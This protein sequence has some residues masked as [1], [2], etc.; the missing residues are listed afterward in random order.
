MR[1]RDL[2][3]PGRLAIGLGFIVASVGVATFWALAKTYGTDAAVAQ[4]SSGVDRAALLRN[5][6]EVRIAILVGSLFTLI[7]T[8][9]TG[10]IVARSVARAAAKARFIV[11]ALTNGKFDAEIERDDGD[12]IGGLLEALGRM[13][14]HLQQRFLADTESMRAMTFS[15][16]ALDAAST[17][18]MMI[19]GQ[20]TIRALNPALLA[21]FKKAAADIGAV[22]PGFNPQTLEGK[23]L[24]VFGPFGRGVLAGLASVKSSRR[25]TLVLGARTFVITATPILAGAERLG[26]VLEWDDQTVELA[27]EKEIADLVRRAGQGDFSTRVN[28][29][30][31]EGFFAQLGEGVNRLMETSSQGLDEVL[32]ILGSLASGDLTQ[33][34]TRDYEGTFGDIKKDAN[35]TVVQLRKTVE[36]IRGASE[37]INCA[38]A[39]MAQGNGDLS[40]RTESQGASL[41]ETASSMEQLTATVRQNAENARQANQLAIGASDVAVK[42]GEVVAQVV[43]TMESITDSSKKIAEIIGV[44]DGIAFQTNILALNA[45][46]EAARAGEQGRGFAVVATEVRNLAQ[47]SAEAAKEIKGLIGDSS[48]KVDTGSRLVGVAGKTMEDIVLAVKRVTDIMAEISAASIE[49][50]AGIEQVNQAI[51]AMDQATQQNAAVVE[52]AAAAAETME[53]QAQLLAQSVAT[54]RSSSRPIAP[55][56]RE[57]RPREPR[58]ATAPTPTLTAAAPSAP[59]A[60]APAPRAAPPKRVAFAGGDNEDWEEF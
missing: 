23:T 8:A 47:R 17:E 37:A 9:L 4:L 52:Q 19:D 45:A 6:S 43:Q 41:E 2:T 20:G 26:V 30:G 28:V 44:I 27:I 21:G 40:R 25:E 12:E 18:V 29:G 13:R 14:A 36:E 10:T 32:R 24:E 31:R 7:V 60:P 11:E 1:W 35:K 3:F 51:V 59:A 22:L 48:G 15:K 5:I 58:I 39:E 53:E 34:I 56:G 16:Q 42:G 55:P 33:E 54:F 46:V 50:S 49:Q 38:A 57:N